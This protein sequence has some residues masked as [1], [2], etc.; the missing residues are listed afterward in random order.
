[1]KSRLILSFLSLAVLAGCAG[2]GTGKVTEESAE[3]VSAKADR[4]IVGHIVTMDENKPVAEAMTVKDGI[5]QYVGSRRVAE[6]MSDANT[7]VMDYGDNY[8]YPGFLESH[9][10]GAAAGFRMAGQADLGPCN[11]I[12]ECVEVMKAWIA[13][14][15][16]KDVYLGCGWRPWIISNPDAASLDAICPDK[17]MALNSVDGHSMWVNSAMMKQNGIDREYAQKMGAAQVHV[18]AD[19]NP[20]GLLTE[21][22][23]N[24]VIASIQS[25]VEDYKEYILAWQD[26][27]FAHGYTAATEAG[28][29]LASPVT[30]LAYAALAEEGKLKLRTYAY[31]L[32]RDDSDTPDVD[33][34]IA[35]EMAEDLNS[36]YFRVIGLKIFIDGVIEARTGWM[37]NDYLDE[38]GYHGLERYSNHDVAVRLIENAGRNGMGVHAHTIGDGAVRFMMDAIAEAET[39]TGNFDQRNILVH[40][41]AVDPED[42]RRFGE[43]NVIAG[44]ASLWVPKSANVL[45]QEVAYIGAEQ[46]EKSYPIKSFL[47]AG[48]VVVSHTD[49]PVSP[50]MSIPETV[51]TGVLRKSPGKGLDTQRGPQEGVT[52]MDVLKS[53]T[54]NVAYLWHMEDR[55]GSLAPGKVANVTVYDTDFL[56]APIEEVPAAKLISTVIDGEEVYSSTEK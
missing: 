5:I 10:H 19:G 20:A 16:D 7:V 52:R 56:N 48:A 32:V 51:Y 29:E 21:S 6:A 54:T 9:A 50:V 37:L 53:L 42:I 31:H 40:L 49:F 55:L 43:Y 38:P 30:P 35:V 27:A 22:A 8:I 36:E 3:P 44:T 39:E 45:K 18:D 28:V 1:M 11:T 46:A 2:N 24:A 23:A 14:H 26:F 12:E 25:T 17:P 47:D 34:D 13:E 41:Q 4:I 15:P 33:S